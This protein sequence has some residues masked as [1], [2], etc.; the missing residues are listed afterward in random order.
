MK[1]PIFKGLMRLEAQE[2]GSELCMV[3]V[4][5]RIR[6]FRAATTHYVMKDTDT[7]GMIFI[8]LSFIIRKEPVIRVELAGFLLFLFAA[9]A[10]V[11]RNIVNRRA[12]VVLVVEVD[13]T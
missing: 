11:I 9:M 8:W 3:G 7:I 4:T 2:A 1:I 5:H 10:K 6:D 13:W 12:W